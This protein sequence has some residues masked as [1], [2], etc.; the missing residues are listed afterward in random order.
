[1]LFW[2]WLYFVKP[3]WLLVNRYAQTRNDMHGFLNLMHI[4]WKVGNGKVR[5]NP[6]PLRNALVKIDEKPRFLIT[7]A[8]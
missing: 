6:N 4:R 8:N 2:L 5:F 7:F 1:M 3:L